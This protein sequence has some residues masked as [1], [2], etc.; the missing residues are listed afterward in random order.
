MIFYD[1]KSD[2][3]WF[4]SGK[5][6]YDE[7]KNSPEYSEVVDKPLV[8]FDNGSGKVYRYKL[9]FDY[10]LENGEVM[11]P[12]NPQ[13]TYDKILLKNSGKYISSDELLGQLVMRT[14]LDDSTARTYTNFYPDWKVGVEYQKDW[15]VRYNGDLYRIAQTHTSQAQWIPGSVGTES[16]Y[17]NISID[18][19]GHELWKQ[20]TGA[21]DSYNT[22]DIVSYNGTLYESLIDGNVW[23]PDAYPAGWKV[24]EE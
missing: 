9:L 22:G 19:S 7:M 10:A 14:T 12:K 1:G 18:S 3:D 17:T 5:M 11:N 6:T 8:L 23:S 4:Y 20:P 2:I 21:H 24:Y 15:V 16:L 13:E